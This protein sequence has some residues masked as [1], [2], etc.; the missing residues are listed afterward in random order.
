MAYTPTNVDVYTSAFSGA[1]AGMG[2]SGWI[3]SPTQVNYDLVT[4]IAGAFAAALDTAWNSATALNSLECKAIV[5]IAQTD[6]QGRGPGPLADPR[7]QSISN[8]LAA[9]AACVALVL[10]SDSYF[11]A[12]GIDPG[13]CNGTSGGSITPLTAALVGDD[14]GTA[15]APTGAYSGDKAFNGPD[16]LQNL[17][18]ALGPTNGGGIALAPGTYSGD[19]TPLI[20]AEKTVRITGL[21][22]PNGTVG[23]FVQI[24]GIISL[25]ASDSSCA[26][27][28]E[29]LSSSAEISDAGTGADVSVIRAH[30]GPITITGA[31]NAVDASIDDDVTANICTVENSLLQ[32]SFTALG[33]CRAVGSIFAGPVDLQTSGDV[34]NCRFIDDLRVRAAPRMAGIVVAGQ[35][36]VDTGGTIDNS[37][38]TSSADT[39]LLLAGADETLKV[40]G[41]KFVGS[42]QFGD[43]NFEMGECTFAKALATTADGVLR[44]TNASYDVS[45]GAFSIASA[46]LEMDATSELRAHVDGLDISVAIHAL[47]LGQGGNSSFFETTATYT[48]TDTPGDIARV[49]TFTSI[50]AGQV[51]TLD[52]TGALGKG[53]FYFDMWAQ[54]N[55]VQVKVGATNIGPNGGDPIP[56]VLPGHGVRHL[57][58][59]SDDSSTVSYTGS[60]KLA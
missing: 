22:I 56:I 51:L 38:I 26:L 30:S 47:S 10:Q 49:H 43:G 59:A 20:I 9:A 27:M 19:D 12:Q 18:D 50:A 34:D 40:T 24:L 25:N 60:V 6:F 1:I 58:Q 3:T 31:L 52:P 45:G 44:L 36:R 21:G 16:S 41:T 14:S 15:D 35:L 4:K 8:W 17:V 13:P 37:D 57:F 55:P 32:E 46:H 53:G 7:F 23:S 39:C 54:D 5:S 11:A 48:F 28:L 2:V 29:T 33:S 42:V